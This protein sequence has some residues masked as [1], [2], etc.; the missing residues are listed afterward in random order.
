MSDNNN[1]EKIIQK[2]ESQPAVKQSKGE[3]KQTYGYLGTLNEQGKKRIQK[4]L[5]WVSKENNCE[6]SS[7]ESRPRDHNLFG[8][9]NFKAE[10]LYA[11][12]F[13]DIAKTSYGVSCP[14]KFDITLNKE[15]T[16][17]SL[18]EKD[19]ELIEKKEVGGE[20]GT[21]EES[22]EPDSE[23]CYRYGVVTLGEVPDQ[24]PKPVL[25]LLYIDP[26]KDFDFVD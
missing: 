15:I 5:T 8:K 7:I 14:L 16:N 24:K 23:R 18:I 17:Q 1:I 6:P 13:Y 20:T 22:G 9:C 4:F 19:G 21:K 10:H 11:E 2:I 12:L 3:V 26:T 25:Y